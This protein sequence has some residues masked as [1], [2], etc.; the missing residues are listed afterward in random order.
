VQALELRG[1]AVGTYACRLLVA[2]Q[3]AG[4]VQR[5]TYLP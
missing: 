2:G 1:L 4:T 5:L 3:P